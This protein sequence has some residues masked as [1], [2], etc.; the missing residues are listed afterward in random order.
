MKQVLYIIVLLFTITTVAQNDYALT[1][2]FEEMTFDKGKLFVALYT[3]KDSF[4]KNPI[5]TT[6]VEIND[7]NVKAVFNNLKPGI[8]AVSSFYDK[9]DNG[10]LDTNAFGIPK[11][12]TAMSNNAKGNFGPPKFKDAKF[13]LSANKTITIK[14]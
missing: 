5:A 1:V 13:E 9:N 4:L 6:I 11:E 3:T 8:Y 12:P 14:F 7:E 2:E 10:K